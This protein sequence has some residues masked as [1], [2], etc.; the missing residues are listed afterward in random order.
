[1]SWVGED[2]ALMWLFARALR[3]VCIELH[4]EIDVHDGMG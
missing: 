1:M 3:C 4:Y 2:A